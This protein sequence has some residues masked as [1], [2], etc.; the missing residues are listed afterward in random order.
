MKEYIFIGLLIV[1]LYL[2]YSFKN[3]NGIFF[4][5]IG[6]LLIGYNKTGKSKKYYMSRYRE[7][8]E[9]GISNN[10]FIKILPFLFV[11]ALILILNIQYLYMGTVLSGSMEPVFKRGDLVLMQK[12][13]TDP[14]VGDIIMFSVAT[15]K[16]LESTQITHRVLRIEN[17][18]FIT[19][20]DANPGEDPWM[21]K[22]SNIMGKA[23]LMGNKP[24]VIEGLGS[25]LVNEAGELK[26]MNKFPSG[27]GGTVLFRSFR[28]IQPIIIFFATVFYFML[29]KDERR[30]SDR[31]SSRNGGNNAQDNPKSN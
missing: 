10:I 24:I 15:K 3:T 20:G 28:D 6:K 29:L 22:K 19:K 23:V 11:L 25:I 21:I 8:K 9:N 1:L 5:F 30:K 12:V 7:H 17:D 27:M 2:L 4:R 13:N 18:Y 31:K 16:F 26:I 14:K